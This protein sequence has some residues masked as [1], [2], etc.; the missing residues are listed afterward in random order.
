MCVLEYASAQ[1]RRPP[2]L[3]MF[4]CVVCRSAAVS[5]YM[6][7]MRVCV[8]RTLGLYLG[9][10]A[11]LWCAASVVRRCYVWSQRTLPGSPTSTHTPQMLMTVMTD[12]RSSAET[13]V[14]AQRTFNHYAIWEL[15][16]ALTLTCWHAVILGDANAKDRSQYIQYVIYGCIFSFLQNQILCEWR[17]TSVQVAKVTTW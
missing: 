13:F 4:S 5:A 1:L 10:F 7:P 2:P 11:L 16:I 8:G 6:C 9:C 14:Q 3:L 17:W 15:K 12:L